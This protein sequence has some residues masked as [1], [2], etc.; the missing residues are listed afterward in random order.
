M[1]EPRFWCPL[2]EAERVA[3]CGG[4]AAQLAQLL[5]LGLPVP[6]GA[7]LTDAA[8]RAFLRH[9]GLSL[10]Q[11]ADGEALRRGVLT[12]NVPAQ[13][14]A[15][16]TACRAVL[17]PD[18]ALIVRSSA[19]GEDGAA[20][21]F[22]GQLDSILDVRPEGL[23]EAVRA[24]WASY[25]SPRV[26]AYQQ[27]RGQRLGGMGVIVQV[28]V[29][30]RFAGVLFT[31]NP[32]PAGAADDLLVEYCP[33]H[34]E[35]LVQGRVNPGRVL[36]SRAGGK[37]RHLA[38]AE[39]GQAPPDAMFAELARMALAVEA[40]AGRP[41]DV[42]W[43]QDE[44]GRLWLVQARPIT[45]APAA[46]DLWSN[47]NVNENY[48]DP[49]CPLLYSI[50]RT[51]YYHYFRGLGLAFGLKPVR[52]AAHEQPLR[53]LIGVHGGRMYYNLT[54]V[55]AVLR[56][57]PFGERLADYFSA[58][59][60]AE[61]PTAAE[62]K[63]AGWRDGAEAAAVGLRALHVFRTL[64]RRVAA[65]ERTVDAFAERTVPEK[66]VGAA[67][68]ALLEALRGFL[69]IRFRRWADAGLADTA[70]MIS[71]GLLKH[72]L[73]REFPGDDQAA[74]HNTLLK[75]LTDLVS[76]APAGAL[77]DLSRRLRTDPALAERIAR[78]DNP[79][80]ARALRAG[81]LGAFGAALD[82]YLRRWGFRRSGELMLTVPSFQEEPEPLFD[83]LRAYAAVA[84]AEGPGERLRRQERERL[85]ETARVLRQL[86]GRRLIRWLPWPDL[87]TVTARLLRW[88]QAA[89]A[90]RERARMRQALLYARCRGIALAIGRH[91]AANGVLA[92]AEDAFW[93]TAEELDDLLAG[94]AQFP[95]PV[96]ELVRLR[97]EAQAAASAVKPPDVF[98]LS[99]GAH[100]TAA[101]AGAAAVPDEGGALTG[102]GACGGQ[103]TGPAAVL[104]DV[105]ECGRL[106]PGDVLVTRQ[107]D[108]GWG[109]AFLLVRGLVLERGGMLSHGAILAREYGIPSVVGVPDAV[110]RIRPG[111]ALQVDGDRGV[112]RLVDR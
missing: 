95:G 51:A 101:T 18:A 34:G 110:R 100:W 105:A 25:W 82:D 92:G 109:P 111:Q 107:T 72:L 38:P 47:A 7:V 37:V 30:P 77:W 20:A 76:G 24:C 8:F 1:S 32:D 73:R 26:L 46:R 81:D 13:V 48:P 85:A 9:N 2:A 74:L 90:L 64:P 89:I 102:V 79:T 66:L 112:V 5:R 59:T 71:Y 49:I 69:A 56:A 42:E 15:A 21:S 80:L 16:A 52:I 61:P 3:A 78:Q 55:H 75:G 22:A 6:A 19:L 50:A 70:A 53:H 54:N 99:R 57:A 58:F 83:L 62:R 36:V 87:A 67:P 97:Q 84:D 14:L 40:A 31:A 94:Y 11:A 44:G 33:G 104:T 27:A 88:C 108:P 63:A 28:Q 29:R 45:T 10:A 41:Q 86:R 93:L 23:A 35:A 91:L 39:G 68:A 43:A 106:R 12:G 96:R 65:F 98:W 103:A 4:K 60:S 17:P